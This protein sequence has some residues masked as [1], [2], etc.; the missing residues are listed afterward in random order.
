M[1]REQK[2]KYLKS[3]NTPAKMDNY[4]ME[5]E[6]KIRIKCEE[7]YQREVLKSVGNFLI[8]IQYALHF[9]EN[10]KFG[11]EEV[12]DFM[13]DLLVTVEGFKNGEFSPSDYEKALEEEGIFFRRKKEK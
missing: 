1:N 7:D 2:R 5:L 3:L 12:N 6:R 13:E 9:N 4:A 10:T 11:N 8:A